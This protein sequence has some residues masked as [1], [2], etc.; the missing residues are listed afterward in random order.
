[1]Y[2]I[3]AKDLPSVRGGGGFTNK[4]RTEQKRIYDKTGYRKKQNHKMIV[5]AL[6]KRGAIIAEK[7]IMPEVKYVPEKAHSF[8]YA[9]KNSN[10]R[11]HKFECFAEVV[12]TLDSF[13]QEERPFSKLTPM[14][15]AKTIQQASEELV[16]RQSK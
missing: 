16:L 5:R 11:V 7:E 15:L 13:F 10:S 9:Q 6:G 2:S 8:M 4:G 3:L 12:P 14:E 1:M